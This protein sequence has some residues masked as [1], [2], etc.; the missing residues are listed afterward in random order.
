MTHTPLTSSG[1]SGVSVLI[2]EDN[3]VNARLLGE[4]L[5]AGGHW[6]RVAEDGNEGLRIAREWLP[7]IVIT[8]LQMPG[9]DGL[10]LTRLLKADPA[11][12]M[13]PIIVVSAHA[14]PEHCAAAKE[15][16]ADRFI[17]KPVRFQS[18]L[19]EVADVLDAYAV[20]S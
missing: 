2:V 20:R 3:A 13:I 17:T 5:K 15:A 12:T 11:T 6:S 18:F 9:M 16:G 19:A 4:I 8:D 7:A 10:T 14:M 1:G